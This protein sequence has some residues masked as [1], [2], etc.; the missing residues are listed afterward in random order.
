M[1]GISRPGAE[2]RGRVGFGLQLGPVDLA[3]VQLIC[4]GAS[5]RVLR[6]P[7]VAVSYCIMRCRRRHRTWRLWGCGGMARAVIPGYRRQR[8]LRRCW[9]GLLH[10][11]CRRHY[12]VVCCSEALKGSTVHFDT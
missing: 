8:H 5:T 11:N 4:P 3:A 7:L 9:A 2:C 12:C 1:D 10:A 6:R